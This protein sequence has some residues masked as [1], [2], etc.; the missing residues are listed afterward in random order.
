MGRPQIDFP[1]RVRLLIYSPDGRYLAI[2]GGDVARIWDVRTRAF[3]TPELAHPAA[4]TTLA[5]HPEGRYLATGCLDNQARLFAASGKAAIPLW[6]P[7]PHVQVK[8]GNPWYPTFFSPPLFVD[9]GRGLITYGG[10]KVLTLRAV[11]TGAE[12]RTIDAPGLAGTDPT[13]DPQVAMRFAAIEASPDGRY[14]AALGFQSPRVQ[15]FEV[16]TGQPIGPVLKHTNTV[17]SAN[18]RPDGQMLLTGSADN[19]ARQWAVPSGEPRS[20]PLDLHR[21]VKVVAFAPGGGSMT[22][23]DGELVRLWALPEEGLPMSRVPLDGKD[24][25]ASLSPDGALLIPTGLNYQ[26]QSTLA[27]ARAFRVAT[28]QPVGPPLRPG[29]VIVDAAFSPDGK[30]VAML[31]VRVSSSTEGQEIVA[32]D[33]SSGRPGWRTK[34]PSDPRSLS[35]RR[36]GRRLAVLCGGGELL[37]FEADS[38]REIRRWAAH[39][40]EPAHHWVNNGKVV[41]SPD[42]LSVL[43]W[44]MGND[45]RVWDADSGHPRYAPI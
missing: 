10:Q 4:V 5:F 35:Y 3:S 38:G 36:D 1:G 12:V 2:A 30:S 21:G 42:G 40:P 7:V 43:T 26:S 27:S 32:W 8:Q 25:F 18:F 31:S 34:L 41:F 29:G 22:T 24:S 45:A 16:A 6:T 33:W 23:Q 28:G 44:G 13:G 39:D 17:F 20:R 19:T 14:L 9:G 37:I 15:L 11:E